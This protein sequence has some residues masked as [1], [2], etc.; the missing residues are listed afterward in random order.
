[1]GND[2]NAQHLYAKVMKMVHLYEDHDKKEK[3]IFFAIAR[4]YGIRNLTDDLTMS[5][6]R[7]IELIGN[8]ESINVTRLAEKM[9]MT[10]GAITKISAKLLDRGWIEKFSLNGNRKEVLF[11]LTPDGQIVYDVHERY[12][13]YVEKFFIDFI[14]R[15]SDEDFQFIDRLV[16][17]ITG[18]LENS[19]AALGAMI[20]SD[21]A[22]Y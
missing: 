12:H 20:K 15:Y 10:K 18:V 9:G 4:Q 1:M 3:D 7:A 16:S 2:A 19:M 6:T 17:D 8:H 11:R 21:R 14:S 5:E 13:Q 22:E